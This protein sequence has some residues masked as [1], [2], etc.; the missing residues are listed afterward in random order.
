MNLPDPEEAVIKMDNS[1]CPN[2]R[3]TD[4]SRYG[5]RWAQ[6][7]GCL[8][9]MAFVASLDGKVAQWPAKP[10]ALVR[11]IAQDAS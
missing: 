6:C 3:G 8:K 7:N 5:A 10:Q 1:S 4:I 9:T 2:C 11:K